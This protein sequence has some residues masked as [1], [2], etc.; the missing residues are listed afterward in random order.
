MG[1]K[2]HHNFG[3]FVLYTVVVEFAEFIMSGFCCTFLFLWC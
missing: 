2:H 3:N 1:K